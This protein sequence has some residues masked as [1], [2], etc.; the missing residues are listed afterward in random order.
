MSMIAELAQPALWREYQ[1]Y[2]LEK[3]RLGSREQAGLEEYI[4][5]AAYLPVVER[6]ISG[7]GFGVPQ[8]KLINKLGSDKKRVVY[9]FEHD[10]TMV[11]KLMA[12]LLYRYDHKHPE[13]LYSFRRGFG[14]HRAIRSIAATKDIGC[15]WCCKL[16][17]SNYFNSIDIPTLLPILEDVLEDDP[18]LFGFLKALLTADKAVFEGEIIQ[19]KRGVMAGTPISPFLANL[20]LGE[21]DRHFTGLGLPYARYS[22]DV[23]IFAPAQADIEARH[24]EALEMLRRYGL[25]ANAKKTRILPPGE[26]WEFLGVSYHDGEIDLSAA[27][28]DKLKGKIRRKA[29]ALRRW[30]L[31][32]GAQPERAMRA[33]I[34]VFNTKFFAGGDPNELTWARWF[35][36]LITRA[37]GLRE[38]DAYLQQ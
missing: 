27:T 28:M 7:A 6:I 5:S 24:D 29:R 38:M 15:M 19:E 30:M 36:P 13:G 14:A 3:S 31:K 33:M 25:S 18:E 34:R 1:A 16:D 22:D 12:Y 20:Y 26:P 32:K 8:K 17:V 9:T 37:D 21:L 23:I 2:K 10:E 35:F 4:S 11:L